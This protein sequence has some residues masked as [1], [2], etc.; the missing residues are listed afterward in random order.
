M[1]ERKWEVHP[2][3][4]R[5]ERM[6]RCRLEECRAACC[7]HGVWLD[8]AEAQDILAHAALIAPHMP[9]G[10]TNPDH[11]LDERRE[12]DAFVPS[13]EVV[14]T[15]VLDAGWHYGGTACVFLR[16]DYK[17]ALQVAGE[18]SAN[19]P[20][21]FKPFYCILHPL[22]LD[23]NGR[24]TLDKS[25]ALLDEPA[26]CLRPAE[27]DIPLLDTFRPELEHFLGQ[28]RYQALRRKLAQRAE[29]DDWA[30][31]NLAGADT[32]W[33]ERELVLLPF[34]PK[35]QAVVRRLVLE[36]L[37]EHWGYLDE[38]MNP[39]LDDIAASYADGVFLTAWK[40]NE[41]VG[42]GAFRPVS[43]DTVQIMR[44]SVGKKWRRQG[45][46]RMILEALCHRAYNSG[47]SRAILE[48]TASWEEVIAFYR[49]FG[50]ERTSHEEDN[51]W[52]EINLESVCTSRG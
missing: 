32:G 30:E 10:Y 6:R 4:L 3:L 28:E 33:R 19:H 38:R 17:C 21:R 16:R 18:A 24:I 41:L 7:L 31:P 47:Y 51:I 15:A 27:E 23:E 40:G 13:G 35:D 2:R 20:W 12:A 22:D 36:G 42:T 45:I 5:R 25:E 49:D 8:T 39:D 29:A 44:M 50:F 48:T 14:H 11:W 46:G 37:A 34:K 43:A 52:F 1:S 26:S 9:P